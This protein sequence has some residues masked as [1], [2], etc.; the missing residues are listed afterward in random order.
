MFASFRFGPMPMTARD[1][2]GSPNRNPAFNADEYAF[3]AVDLRRARRVASLRVCRSFL[4]VAGWLACGMW[5]VI[6]V[7][8]AGEQTGEQIYRKQCA[9]CHGAAGEGTPDDYPHLLTGDKSPAQLARLITR[10]MPY[11]APGECVGDDASRVAAYIYESFYSRDA[12][13]RLKPPRIELSRLTIPQYRNTVADLIGSFRPAITVEAER[14]LRGEYSRRGRK[15]G[16]NGSINRLDPLVQF[17][18]GATSPVAPTEEELQELAKDEKK[19]DAKKD[20]P[21]AFSVRWQG[22]V[23]AQ[24]TGEYAFIVKTENAT[25]LWVNDMSQMLIDAGVKSGNDTEYKATV[26]LLGG[27]YYPIRLE[28]NRT[29]EKTASIGLWWQPPQRAAEVIPNRC[30]TPSRVPETFVLAAAFPPDDRSIGYERGSSIS[31]AWDQ[32]ATDAAI[33]TAGYVVAHFKE[34]AGAGDQAPGRAQRLR[35]FCGK[36]AERAFRRPLDDEQKQLYLDRA[37][38]E[39][40]PPDV[41]AKRAVL[42][43]LKSP[44]FLYPEIAHADDGF[45]IASRLS[46]GLWDSSPDQ[47]LWEAARNQQ[48]ATR[49]Q[50][51]AQATRMTGD[52]R[53]RTKLRAFFLHWLRV[54]QVAD[55]PKDAQAFPGFDAAVVSDLKTSLDLF[56][57]DVLW[58]DASDFRQL[59]LGDSL[60][61]NGRLSQYYGGS[62][63]PEAPFQRVALEPGLRAGVLTHPYLTARFAYMGTSSPIHRGVFLMRSLL[64]RTLRPPPEAVVPLP[65]DLHADLTTRERVALQTSPAVCAGCH[66]MINPL[67]FGLENFDAVG[68][69]RSEDHGRPVDATGTLELTS[70]ETARFSGARELATLLANNP[71]THAAFVEQLFHHLVK[72]PIRAFSFQALPDLVRSFEASGCNVRRLMVEIMTLVARPPQ[73]AAE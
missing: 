53:A 8:I 25:R 28:L 4:T 33:E 32:A 50:I 56:L 30:L 21:H 62:L 15:K 68:R 49:E 19:D 20:D 47:P 61:L 39:A 22:S 58:S 63:P 57:D 48:L 6:G 27:R 69:F 34:L 55:L 66:A 71:E 9:S 72:Q 60:F 46:Y 1:Q 45:A 2:N 18:F 40:G 51:A 38:A 7:S 64:G 37:F 10:S 70:G 29:R 31:K 23:F 16:N 43:A 24:E 11:D 52:V 3:I 65:P 26:P 17:D 35:E 13:A 67:G 41:A 5:G 36:F 44:R 73:R 54:D 59:L 14:G 12:Q 42:L